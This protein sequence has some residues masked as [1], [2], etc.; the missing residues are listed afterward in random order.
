MIPFAHASPRPGWPDRET[1]PEAEPEERG[2]RHGE[3]PADAPFA[4]MTPIRFLR[5]A[6]G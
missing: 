5:P 2:Q 4:G 1:K 3:Y 6:A